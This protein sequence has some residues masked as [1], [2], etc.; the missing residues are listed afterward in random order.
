MDAID[1]TQASHGR[2]GQDAAPMVA[3]A[4]TGFVPSAVFEKN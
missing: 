4:P 2:T 1:I 3:S